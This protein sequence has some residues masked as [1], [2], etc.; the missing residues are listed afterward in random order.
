MT[1]LLL[2]THNIMHARFEK[3]PHTP[4]TSVYFCLSLFCFEKPLFLV[5]FHSF[6]CVLLY[7]FNMNMSYKHTAIAMTIQ[8][9]EKQ[10]YK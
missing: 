2:T 3:K 10:Q 9:T 4:E 8:E 6:F 5:S 7:I 1:S